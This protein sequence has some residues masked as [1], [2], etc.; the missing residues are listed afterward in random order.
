MSRFTIGAAVA[1]TLLGLAVNTAAAQQDIEETYVVEALG[2]MIPV[3]DSYAL[4]TY[5]TDAFA[6]F[7]IGLR[8]EPGQILIAPYSGPFDESFRLASSE[9]R[10][11]LFLETLEYVGEPLATNLANRGASSRMVRIHNGNQQ[12]SFYGDAVPLA[13]GMLEACSASS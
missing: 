8:S 9:R 6:F 7:K 1:T 12:V 5:R 10:G 3:P 13:N 2:C 4:N 11:P